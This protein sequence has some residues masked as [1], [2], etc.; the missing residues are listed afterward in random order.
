MLQAS[1]KSCASPPRRRLGPR[2][3]SALCDCPAAGPVHT[4][5]AS[6]F[7]QLTE[8]IEHAAQADG[9]TYD[10]SWLPWDKANP[11]YSSLVDNLNAQLITQ[12]RGTA[13]GIAVS[14]W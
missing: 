4:H 3:D 14:E 9:F 13:G 12:Q 6:T 1:K 11:S 7:D 10:S 5:L 8:A 2:S